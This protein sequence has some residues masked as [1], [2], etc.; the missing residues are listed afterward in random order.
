[1]C[2]KI[3]M[4]IDV[5]SVTLK[6]VLIDENEEIIYT[7]YSRTRGR[8][9][10]SLKSGIK[11]IVSYLK[12]YKIKGCCT[13]GSGRKMAAALL[14]AD[15]EKNEITT[16]AA[17]A[18]KLRPDI[19]TILEIGGEDS[20][21]ILLENGVPVDFAMNTMCAAGTGAFLDQVAGRLEIP[22]NKLGELARK[23]TQEV[24]ISGRCTVFAESDIIFKQQVGYK[25]EDIIQGLCQAMAANYLNDV[26][27][28]KEISEPIF[29]QGGVAANT[30]IKKAFEKYLKCEVIVPDYYK[31]MGAYGAA[32]I[33]KR[34]SKKKSSMKTIGEICQ[35]DFSTNSFICNKCANKCEIVKFVEQGKIVGY[36]GGR[37][38]RWSLKET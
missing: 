28:G 31:V 19:R 4:G 2:D 7:D 1:M 38:E 23:S 24:V 34:S 27:K 20:K 18:L 14:N 22:V 32:L 13:T 33:V 8:V 29:F 30:G 11:K 36:L 35:S 21:I 12:N 3:Y 10:E 25:I 16:H 6:I 26:G 17:A 5:G 15:I 9:I 37:C